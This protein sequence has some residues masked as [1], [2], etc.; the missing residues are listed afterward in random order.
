[1]AEGK[2]AGKVAIV[3]G[4]SSGIGRAAVYALAAEGAKVAVVARSADVVRAITAEITG[5]GGVALPR[6]IPGR[7]GGARACRADVADPAAVQGVVDQ[8]IG[9]WGQLDLLVA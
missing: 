4:A 1:M 6:G 3:T 5:Q 9:A 8:V 2:L 7:G